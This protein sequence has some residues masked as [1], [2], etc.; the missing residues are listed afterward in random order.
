MTPIRAL[1]L[2]VGLIVVQAALY[3]V[4]LLYRDAVTFVVLACS[5]ITFYVYAARQR[6]SFAPIEI[7]GSVAIGLIVSGPLLHSAM[8]L[9]ANDSLSWAAPAVWGLIFFALSNAL[10]LGGAILLRKVIR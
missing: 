6:R 4:S 8:V 1:L 5:V 10:C 9:T 3:F 2:F 7:L